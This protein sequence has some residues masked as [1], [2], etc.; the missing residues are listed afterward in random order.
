MFRLVAQQL[1]LDLLMLLLV[2]VPTRWLFQLVFFSGFRCLLRVA[3]WICHGLSGDSP[4]LEP[5]LGEAFLGLPLTA[6]GTSAP[7]FGTL[8]CALELAA[9]VES[10]N[11]P[12]SLA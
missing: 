7:S 11:I 12:D 8:G 4:A 10:P 3:Q 6:L 1:L 5:L 9:R 2:V